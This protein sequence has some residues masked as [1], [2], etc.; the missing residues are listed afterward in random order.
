MTVRKAP[1]YVP[2]TS[3]SYG[4]GV[5]SAQVGRARRRRTDQPV[6]PEIGRDRRRAWCDPAVAPP[7]PERLPGP[8]L[9][10][11]RIRQGRAAWGAR[12]TEA[13]HEPRAAVDWD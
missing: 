3:S 2:R 13:D 8:A 1:L 9:R 4:D 11:A 6:A 7:E 10:R 12:R 5:G